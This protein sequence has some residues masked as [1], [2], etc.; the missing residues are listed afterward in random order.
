MP[1]GD[2]KARLLESFEARYL[3]VILERAG[4]N[5]TAAARN[6]GMNRSHLADL[7]RRHGLR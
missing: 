2:A 6:A 3:R 5:I 4:G 7:L 1:Y